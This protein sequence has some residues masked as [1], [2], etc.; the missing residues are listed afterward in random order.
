MSDVAAAA[1]VARATVYRYFP[2]REA[3]LEA[4]GRLALEDIG[5]RLAAARLHGGAGG[6]APQ[7]AS[8]RWRSATRSSA[9]SA[10]SSRWGTGSSS[11]RATAGVPRT[12]RSTS[13]SPL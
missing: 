9:R 1:G 4:L 2:N 6:G 7:P 13:A 12:R 11:W 8:T 5:D 10:P 3:L